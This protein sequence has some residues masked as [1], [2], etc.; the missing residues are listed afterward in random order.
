MA[1]KYIAF[2]E[3][4]RELPE[5]VLGVVF[6][7][8]PGCISFGDDYDEAFCNAH[9]ALSA[10][11]SLMSE[12]GEDIPEPRTFEQIKKEWEDFADWKGTNYAIAYIEL[13]PLSEINKYTISLGA[14]LINA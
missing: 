2:I 4:D 3:L 6:P 13:F 8:F 7:D 14:N 12:S 9:E 10:H 1:K 5:D 11:I